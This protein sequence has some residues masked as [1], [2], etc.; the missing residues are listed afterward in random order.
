MSQPEKFVVSNEASQGLNFRSE[1][2]PSDPT[3]IIATL[4]VNQEVIKLA[5]AGVPNWW[6]VRTTIDGISKEGFVNR[7]FL[8]P[9][10]SQ[11]DVEVHTGVR[12]VHLPTTGKTVKRASKANLPY[13]LTENPPVRRAKDD[14]PAQRVEAIRQLIE[15]LDVPDSERY[16]PD[17]NTYCNIYAYDYCFLT[18]A[19]LPRVWWTGKALIRL[20]AGEAVP[21]IYGET[22]NEKLANELAGWFKQWGADFG[23]RRTLDLNELQQAANEGRVCISVGKSKPG[24]HHGHGHIVAVVPENDNHQATRSNGKVVATV[25]SQAGA[26]NAK[27][28]V[29][30][31]WNDG[32]Y[33]EFGHWIHD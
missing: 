18:G 17:G 27:Y 20:A 12:A 8:R 14:P 9:A 7:K 15:W 23:W 28:K 13:P 4:P 1:P 2:D 32:T 16:R 19:Y 26:H 10:G 21:V 11:S 31:W 6:K 5:D 33:E 3:N 29:D 25:Q 24:F 30:H 22:V